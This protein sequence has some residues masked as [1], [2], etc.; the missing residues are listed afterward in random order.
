MIGRA[1]ICAV[2]G[3]G[4]AAVLS[5]GV[6]SLEAFVQVV[7]VFGMLRVRTGGVRFGGSL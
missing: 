6:W 4:G 5:G 3:Y 7:V 2:A 1:G